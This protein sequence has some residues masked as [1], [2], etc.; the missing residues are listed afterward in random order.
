MSGEGDT[1]AQLNTGHMM[2]ILNN[3]KDFFNEPFKLSP[4]KD[5]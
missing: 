5:D 1:A 4:D 2:V 3:N